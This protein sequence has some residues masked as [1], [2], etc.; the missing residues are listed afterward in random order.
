MIFISI[1][2][3]T[4]NMQFIVVRT[5]QYKYNF[6]FNQYVMRSTFQGK[7]IFFSQTIIF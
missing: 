2:K 4:L 1:I 3:L 7:I 5:L 6:V